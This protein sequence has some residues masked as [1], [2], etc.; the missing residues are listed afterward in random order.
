MIDE[1]Q[2]GVELAAD[3]RRRRLEGRD[4]GKEFRIE[5]SGRADARMAREH[6]V[7]APGDLAAELE[8]RPIHPFAQTERHR[9]RLLPESPRAAAVR[10]FYHRRKS[11]IKFEPSSSC[12]A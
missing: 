1:A 8:E 3:R 10:V 6:V 4:P 11:T 2:Q 9:Y 12:D 5:E 7:D